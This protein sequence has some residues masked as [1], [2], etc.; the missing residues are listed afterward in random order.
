MKLKA[1]H[2]LAS[3]QLYSLISI[4]PLR[5][6]PS[7]QAPQLV[8]CPSC[9]LASTVHYINDFSFLEGFFFPLNPYTPVSLIITSLNK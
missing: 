7:S 4:L 5:S 3:I 9:S 1:M 8:F 6:T 2:G